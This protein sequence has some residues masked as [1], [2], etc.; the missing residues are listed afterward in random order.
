MDEVVP[1]IEPRIVVA[2]T[3]RGS[4]R[5]AEIELGG[6]PRGAVLVLCD[7][8]RLELET[9][10]ALNGFAAHGYVSLAADL[11][12][13]LSAAA[14]DVDLLRDVA[15]LI[16]RLSRR[17][18]EPQQI[19]LVGYGFGGR[20]ALLAASEFVLGAA[21]SVAPASVRQGC[22]PRGP[23]L[24][25]VARPV[26]TPW[27]GLFGERDPESPTTAVTELADRLV[28]PSPAYVELVTYPGVDGLF[29][30]DA[31]A[32]D[33]HA[34]CFDSWQRTLEW[35]NLRVVPRPTPLAR[36]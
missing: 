33:V 10:E 19:G 2:D 3:A 34:A 23:A 13:D 27:L 22:S 6:V 11:A 28:A 29:H 14:T 30:R 15:M 5:I 32:A 20:V 1:R 18:W 31:A 4:L 21:V 7:V 9:V 25:E 36:Q 8:G 24:V 16:E 35:L 12:A 26:H 17:G